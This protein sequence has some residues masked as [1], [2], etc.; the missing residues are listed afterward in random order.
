MDA[1]TSELNAII[2]NEAQL[3]LAEKRTSL[4]AVRTGIAVIAL[5]LSLV[6]LLIA[7]S[8]FYDAFHVLHWLI[9]LMALNVVLVFLGAYLIIRSLVRIH[10]YDRLI[11]EIKRKHS[12]VAEFID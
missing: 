8:R 5:P 3:I 6:S 2:I 12:A 11:K 10:H 4:A 1:K 9:P 7:T